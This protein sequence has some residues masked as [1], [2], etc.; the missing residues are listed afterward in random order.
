MTGGDDFRVGVLLQRAL[1]MAVRH[2]QWHGDML[3]DL[4]VS[5]GPHEI[6]IPWLAHPR[7]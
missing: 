4:Q 7:L 3:R 1:G 2:S 5:D 6:Y